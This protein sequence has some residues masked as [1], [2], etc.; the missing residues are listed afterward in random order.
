MN[1]TPLAMHIQEETRVKNVFDQMNS[2]AIQR[3]SRVTNRNCY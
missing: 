3:E 2:S 1:L